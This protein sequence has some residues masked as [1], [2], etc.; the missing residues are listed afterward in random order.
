MAKI[1]IV[2]DDRE[3]ASIVRSFLEFDNHSVEVFHT[4][5]QGRA[6]L[7]G[8]QYNLIILDWEIPEISGIEMLQEYRQKGGSAPVLM[9]TGKD[10]VED[11]EAGLDCGADDYLTKPFDMKELGARIR[12]LLRRSKGTVSTA[13]Q[14]GDIALDGIAHR[15]VQGD[16]S[17]ALTPREYQFLEF[18]AGHP[19]QLSA[20]KYIE[21]IW[22]GDADVT[23]DM[24]KTIVKRLRK[25]LDAAGAI[26]CPHLFSESA[27][28]ENT[29]L[30]NRDEAVG[31]TDQVQH[32]DDDFDPVLGMIVD[33]KYE[34]VELIGGGGAG[35]VYKAKHAHLNTVVAVKLLFPHLS[36]NQ[37]MVRRFRREAQIVSS[38]THPNILAVQDY[39]LSG[40][41]QPYMV[42]ELI[43]GESLSDLLHRRGT[44]PLPETIEV[45]KQTCEGLAYAHESGAVHRDVKPSNIMLIPQPN[46]GFLVK[47][48][49]FGLAKAT[50]LDE[51]TAKLTRT[52]EVFGSP[53]Y[54]SPEQCR[55]LPADQRTDIYALGCIMYE[56]LTG[57]CPF[58]GADPISTILKQVTDEPPHLV[59]DDIDGETRDR[60]ERIIFKCLAKNPADRYE[61]ARQV[62]ADLDDVLK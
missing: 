38:L 22:A 21:Q 54:M 9:L 19:E 25:K 18:V 45:L 42:M 55:G 48:V 53:L 20:E 36:L 44:I 1:L 40:E 10:Q 49:D 4:G 30:A 34:L 3:L 7:L 46:D 33:S 61:S 41:S 15:A 37:E 24:L 28:T 47:L 35:L 58:E 6:K 56:L 2:E 16:K 39:G 62:Q 23:V 5:G 60:M 26:I 17:V 31:K 51:Q 14:L 27:A 57:K 12:A 29:M 50:E 8:S 11:K 52:G 59:L 43:R 32:I 13:P